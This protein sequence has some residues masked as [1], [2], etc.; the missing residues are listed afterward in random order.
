M[1]KSQIPEVAIDNALASLSSTLNGKEK[2][3][4]LLYALLEGDAQVQDL[5]SQLYREHALELDSIKDI[6]GVVDLVALGAYARKP[7]SPIP[8]IPARYHIMARAISGIYAWI[9]PAGKLQLLS[10]RYR[11][12]LTGNGQEC[13]VFELA[14]CNRCGEVLLVG[15]EEN[16]GGHTYLRQPPGVGDDPIV[17]LHWFTLHSGASDSKVDEDDV[18]DEQKERSEERRVGKECRSRWSPYH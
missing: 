15:M 17:D 12:Y 10:K 6:S 8:L 14:S 5:R 2:C 18:A 11:R 7:G 13:A 16:E 1:A 3:Q 4:A 9:D